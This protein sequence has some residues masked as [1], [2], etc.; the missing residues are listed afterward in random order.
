MKVW[1]DWQIDLWWIEIKDD[2][3]VE[4]PFFVCVSKVLARLRI[5]CQLCTIFSSSSFQNN[6]L[7]EI[8]AFLAHAWRPSS[9][10]LQLFMENHVR[11]PCQSRINA[12]IYCWIKLQDNEAKE[13]EKKN[14]FWAIV[15]SGSWHNSYLHLDEMKIQ[16]IQLCACV[17]CFFSIFIFPSSVFASLFISA[18]SCRGSILY[19]WCCS[20][21]VFHFI[22][23]SERPYM[24]ALHR[25][26]EKIQKKKKK[27]T[28]IV[29]TNNQQWENQMNKK[30]EF[31]LSPKR[32]KYANW[33]MFGRCRVGNKRNIKCAS[34]AS[35]NVIHIRPRTN[36]SIKSENMHIIY[37]GLCCATKPKTIKWISYVFF[38]HQSQ[39]TWKIFLSFFSC[40]F[41][42]VLFVVIVENHRFTK[43]KYYNLNKMELIDDD[44][45]IF[46]KVNIELNVRVLLPG[47]KPI[48][49]HP[50]SFC[51]CRMLMLKKK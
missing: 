31:K 40:C 3:L 28:R 30:K 34:N 39:L 7:N 16:R 42:F 37:N 2:F 38:P 17:S 48:N 5:D 33:W 15:G 12:E 45:Q 1:K 50:V 23:F 13:S 9:T 36:F 27:K 51:S 10:V 14:P 47:H 35:K 25:D 19:F 49:S 46:T 21:F 24:L 32:Q 18:W 41:F 44:G 29:S 11:R 4:I 26:E 8:W 43:C 20:S 22:C 6:N